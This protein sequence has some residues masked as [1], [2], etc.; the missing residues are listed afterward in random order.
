MLEIRSLDALL[1][2]DVPA[3]EYNMIDVARN[4]AALKIE[5]QHS[6]MDVLLDQRY[7]RV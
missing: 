1:V 7:V 6:T 4:A 2:T 3:I 5:S